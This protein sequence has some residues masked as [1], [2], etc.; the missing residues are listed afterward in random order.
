[1]LIY[2]CFFRCQYYWQ[3]F[4]PCKAVLEI[5]LSTFNR[6]RMYFHTETCLGHITKRKSFTEKNPQN[7]GRDIH[8]NYPANLST[9]TQ[10]Y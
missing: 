9:R 1:M 5:E 4:S 3:L 7:N 8:S 2:G 10:D 6:P